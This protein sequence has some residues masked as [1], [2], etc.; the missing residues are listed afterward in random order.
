MFFGVVTGCVARSL[1]E[2][3]IQPPDPPP[4]GTIPPIPRWDG[5]PEMMRVDSDK[6]P[7]TTALLNV[8]F[9][10]TV[11]GLIGPLDYAFRHY[12]I[13]PATGTT[14]TVSGSI[15]SAPVSVPTAG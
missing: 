2:P 3:G 1:R 11:T 13:L 12:T 10:Q 8:G 14:P 4:A 9:G 6:L 5:N 7:G 15:V